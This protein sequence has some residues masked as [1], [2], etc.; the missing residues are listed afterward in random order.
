M[1]AIIG[2]LSVGS[3]LFIGWYWGARRRAHHRESLALRERELSHVRVSNAKHYDGSPQLPPRLVT[4]ELV[5]GLDRFQAFLAALVNFFG[6]EMENVS[7]VMARA[8]RE[9]LVRLK[10]DAER[11][12]YDA[13][14]NLR[15]ETADIGNDPQQRDLKVAVIGS[16]TAYKQLPLG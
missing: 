8:R 12:G 11:A 10:A 7:E 16:A 9:A 15:L 14:A 13:L 3:L 6:G 1:E 4:V 2:I 5:W